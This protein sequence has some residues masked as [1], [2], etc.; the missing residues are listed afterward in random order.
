MSRFLTPDQRAAGVAAR[1]FA[2]FSLHQAMEAGLSERQVLDR[3]AAG[4][5]VRRARSVYAVAGSPDSPMQRAMVAY[6]S[7]AAAG[8]V[9]SHLT[10]A[11]ISGLCP[12]PALPH[13]T[14]PPNASHE[15]RSARVHRGTVPPADRQHRHGLVV[16]SPSRTIADLSTCLDRQSLCELVDQAFVARLATAETTLRAA[17]RAGRRRRGAAL[18]RSVVEVWTP[19]IEPGSVAEMRVVRLLG[20]YGVAQLELQHQVFD[21]DGAFVARLD[22]ADPLIRRGF[23]YEGVLVHNP[24][25]WVRDEPRYQRLKD[26]GWRIDPITKAD[27]L[28]GE[29][30]LRDLA[31]EWTSGRLAI[32]R[33]QTDP[34]AR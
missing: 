29:R 8:G 19:R 5:F 14:V 7:V 12:H 10:A 23:E 6:L 34:R 17:A 11:A 21:D 25:A 2:A 9:V 27:L 20:D 15:A 33:A 32:L 31:E 24:R 18:L 22:I 13:V 30:R 26:L 16:T 1:Q 28:P 3:A 4:R